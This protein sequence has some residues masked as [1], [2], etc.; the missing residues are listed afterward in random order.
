M[1]LADVARYRLSTQLLAPQK[2]RK[3]SEAVAWQG[4]TQAQDFHGAK[5]S[6]GLRSIGTTDA[7]IEQALADRT[8]VRTWPMRG[9][10]H[11]VAPDDI[12]WM[13]ALLTPSVIAASKRRWQQLALTDRI[14]A[15]SRK[16][17]TDAL[18]GGQQ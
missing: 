5:W 12:R 2:F 18:H 3:P 8:I 4:A 9:T 11:F 10:L 6:V 15:R 16:A 7:T 17:L 14:F 1:T 13:L